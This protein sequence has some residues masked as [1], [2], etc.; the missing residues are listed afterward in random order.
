MIKIYTDGA[1]Q[2]KTQAAGLAIIIQRHGQQKQYKIHIAKVFD[3]HQAEF[4][5]LDQAL[6]I[7]ETENLLGES[8]FFYSDSKIV[9]QSVEKE[10]VK[11][12]QYRVLLESILCR[13]R[14]SPLAFIQWL[15]EK[16][17]KGADV[18]AKQALHQQGKLFTFI[19]E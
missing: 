5:A 2:M 8:L 7:L 14:L 17:N 4:M 1:Y 15:P 9:V 13:F 6:R 18:L 19:D 16:E 3:N 12:T 10:Y 11:E